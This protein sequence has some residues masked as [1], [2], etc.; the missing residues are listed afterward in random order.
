MNSLLT[1]FPSFLVQGKDEEKKKDQIAEEEEEENKLNEMLDRTDLF[2]ENFYAAHGRT[3]AKSSMNITPTHNDKYDEEKKSFSVSRSFT[4]QVQYKNNTF[5]HSGVPTRSMTSQYSDQKSHI[6]H[7]Y[8][9]INC[10]KLVTGL[11]ERHLQSSTHV[12][13]QI[14][15]KFTD[16]YVNKYGNVLKGYSQSQEDSQGEIYLKITSAVSDLQQFIRILYEGMNLFYNLEKL[17]M[18]DIAAKENLFCRDNI[19]NFI[20]SI[21]LSVPLYE[22][23]FGLL[24]IND[25]NTEEAFQKNLKASSKMTPEDMGVP[26]EYC[27]NERTLEFY[28]GSLSA[29]LQ[30]YKNPKN[31]Q[32]SKS[33]TEKASYSETERFVE[34]VMSVNRPNTAEIEAKKLIVEPFQKCIDTLKRIEENRS[35]IHKMKTIVK[36]AELIHNSIYSFY[37][38]FNIDNNFKLDSDQMLSIFIYIVARAGV[39]SLATQIK[40]IEK[41]ATNN[42]LNSISGYY[43]TTLEAC[44][45]CIINLEVDEE[46]AS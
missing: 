36:T 40:M 25:L 1:Q 5:I 32:R 28:Y 42:V 31:K 2:E 16:F 22:Q 38:A 4:P 14:I 10:Y 45:N 23:V 17:K 39:K 9:S 29:G 8:A 21:V 30:N 15:S 20:T 26:P 44:I 33:P 3:S 7:L 27:L 46:T 19:L 37:K 24:R 34:N 18:G 13:N 41:F 43:A 12:F 11:I 6:E 35:P